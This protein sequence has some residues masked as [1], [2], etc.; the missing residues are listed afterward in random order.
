MYDRVLEA[1]GHDVL[2]EDPHEE[3]AARLPPGADLL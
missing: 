3:H 2:L 1:F